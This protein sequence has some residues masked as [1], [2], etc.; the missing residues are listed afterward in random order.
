MLREREKRAEDIYIYI[1]DVARSSW[2]II[3]PLRWRIF[4]FPF[5]AENNLPF[6]LWALYNNYSEN[7]R[8]LL[9]TQ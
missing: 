7:R 4:D 2:E 6:S 5:L 9:P 8:S 3:L 1:A